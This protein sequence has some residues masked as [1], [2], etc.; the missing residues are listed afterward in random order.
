MQFLLV[1]LHRIIRLASHRW[2]GHEVGTHGDAFF[3]AFPKATEAVA[4]V[5]DILRAMAGNEWPKGVQVRVRMGLHT[6][7]PWLVEEGYVGMD[8]HRAARIAHV[9]H[10]DRC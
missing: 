8:V 3:T 6:G 9:D 2:L 4:A 5:A 1:V 10:G 7:E